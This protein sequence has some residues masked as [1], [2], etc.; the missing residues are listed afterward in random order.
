M[1]TSINEEDL[2]AKMIE[3]LDETIMKNAEHFKKILGSLHKFMGFPY[4]LKEDIKAAD[5]VHIVDVEKDC[6][7]T[8]GHLTYDYS[9]K[10]LPKNNK[11]LFETIILK[12]SNKWKEKNNFRIQHIPVLIKIHHILGNG[13]SI[14]NLFVQLFGDDKYVIDNVIREFNKRYK[15]SNFWMR[16]LQG[17][18]SFLLLPGFMVC[19]GIK[20]NFNK[21]AFIARAGFGK[22]YF[23]K[24][25][26]DTISVQKIKNLKKKI[27]DCSFTE[28]LL[29][30]ISASC[31]DYF[32]EVSGFF[33]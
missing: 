26:D 33:Q 25:V 32:R 2:E 20:R 31:Y 21:T 17:V 18:Y 29:T 24:K 10:P 13:L 15:R 16:L 8:F 3:A 6:Y 27:G 1:K 4:V 11:L 19:E 5:F 9:M 28:I 30:A 14:M 23:V 12:C 22:Q 7:K